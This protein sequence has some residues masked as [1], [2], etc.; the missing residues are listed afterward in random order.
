MMRLIF[1]ALIFLA[2]NGSAENHKFNLKCKV[3]GLKNDRA[4]LL[5]YGSPVTDTV[6]VRNGVFEISK[7]SI[8]EG[9]YVVSFLDSRLYLPMVLENGKLE[10]I[11]SIYEI[12]G[13]YIQK[14]R[15]KGCQIYDLQREYGDM[16][17]RTVETYPKDL[18]KIY[19]EYTPKYWDGNKTPE[20][21][22]MKK[23][24]NEATGDIKERL[25]K[26]Q[27]EFIKKHADKYVAIDLLNRN[28]HLSKEQQ[29]EIISMLPER[30]HTYPGLKRFA[31]HL[32]NV[33]KSTV[34]GQAH[35][36]TL[37]DINGKKYSL[38]DYRGKYV[39]LDFWSSSCGPCIKMMPHLKEIKEKYKDKDFEI[40]SISADT[41]RKKWEKKVKSIKMTWPSLI[42][43]GIGSIGATT[44]VN[45]YTAQ[46]LPT[47]IIVDKTGKIIFRGIGGD[48]VTVGQLDAKLKEILE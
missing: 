41:E 10:V 7:A 43:D 27:F 30:Y 23:E 45:K 21:M 6:A 33:K 20:V 22:K 26:N 28:P 2:F 44:I 3:G 37:E 1:I 38:K 39:L 19:F 34:G 13:R 11:S 40:I 48:E 5:R 24:W 25:L 12:D 31:E 47:M 42:N 29:M 36:F 8:Q 16:Y 4:V 35:D 32:D 46:A 9:Q 15:M 14:Y 17:A 18:Q